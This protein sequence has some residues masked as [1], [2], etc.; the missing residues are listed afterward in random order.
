MTMSQTGLTAFDS[1]LHTT[2]VWLNEVADRLN[3]AD[4]QHSYRALRAVLHAL[5]DRLSVDQAAALGAQL[6]LLVRGVYYEGWHPGGK[7]LK[8]RKK[9][10]FLAHVV[11]EFP[12]DPLVKP[13][14]VARAVFQVLIRHLS[15]G[16]VEHVKNALPGPVRALWSE[17][18]HSLWV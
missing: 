18:T 16:V 13:D 9:E 15:P 12:Q 14:E 1:T 5:R 2:N 3:G 17:E 11:G 8:E 10:E 7:P 4:R 6:P